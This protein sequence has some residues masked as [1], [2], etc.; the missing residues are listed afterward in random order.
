MK[1]SV[2]KGK[3]NKIHISCDGEYMFT[4]DAEYWFSSP[5]HGREFIEDNEE[6]T[7]FYEAVGSRCAFIAG[8]HLLSYRDHSSKELVT[9]LVQKGHKR[10]YSESAVE[11]LSE[12]GYVNDERYALYLASSLLERKG[13]NSNAIRSE[14]LRKG[15]SREISDNVVE[16][17]DIDPVLR[18]IDL[19]NTKYSRKISDEKGVKRTVASLQRL[20]YKWSD[21]NTAFR[22]LEIET[23][24]TD[25]V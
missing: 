22:R 11:K 4:V 15:I 9:K 21:I 20:G 16:S 3:Q 19:L 5:Y 12:Y 10:E 13:M 17:L 6:L 24:D 23:E 2:S 8:L 7:A 14:L 1:I 25:D 18:I